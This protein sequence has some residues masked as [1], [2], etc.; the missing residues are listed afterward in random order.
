MPVVAALCTYDATL[1]PLILTIRRNV[2]FSPIVAILSV[3]MSLTALPSIDVLASASTSATP[4]AAVA[5]EPTICWNS[6]FFATKSVS[7]FTSTATAE[8]PSTAIATKPSA[9]T[10]PDF[11]AAFAKPLVRSQSTAASKSPS[12]SVNAFFASIMPAPVLSRSSFT[13][14][15]VIA[16]FGS[17]FFTIR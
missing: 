8:P 7:E 2:M 15:A 14:A 5:N 1:S 13:I 6:A 16:I 3:R 10:R 11:L 9:A 4:N 17:S 12:V